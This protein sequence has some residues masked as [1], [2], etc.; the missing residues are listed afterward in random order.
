MGYE[1]LDSPR[2]RGPGYGSRPWNLIGQ[3]PRLFLRLTT[4]VKARPRM[5]YHRK[6]SS[7]VDEALTST[8]LRAV[9]LLPDGGGRPEASPQSLNALRMPGYVL[10]RSGGGVTRFVGKHPE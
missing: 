1:F 3:R 5:R 6:P 10:Q 2:R 8:D 7:Y 9:Q 4:E